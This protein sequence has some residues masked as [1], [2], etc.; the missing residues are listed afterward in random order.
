MFASGIE[1]VGSIKGVKVIPQARTNF[2]L[3]LIKTI[4]IGEKKESKVMEV[5]KAFRTSKNN[6][7][8]VNMSSI[9]NVGKNMKKLIKKTKVVK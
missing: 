2:D 6:S 7:A 1:S 5:T 4:N 9:L 3:G 8:Y